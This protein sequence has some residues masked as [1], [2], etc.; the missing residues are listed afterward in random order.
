MKIGPQSAGANPGPVCYNI[1]GRTAT[2]TDANVVLGYLN[3]EGL[4]GGTRPIY[5]ELAMQVIK[6]Q[7]ADPLAISTEDAAYGA[8]R[9]AASNMIR[10][11]K[12]VSSERGRDPREFALVAFGGNGPLFAAGMAEALGITTII[13]PPYPG[14]FSAFGLLYSDI[15]KHHTKAFRFATHAVR[16]SDL[17]NELAKLGVAASQEFI[18]SG[19]S[20]DRISVDRFAKLQ[21]VG[22]AHGQ[23]VP[24]PAGEVDQ[25]TLDNMV[26]MFAQ[27]HDRT[28][29]HRA[30]AGEL[31]EF[32]SLAIIAR[33]KPDASWNPDEL[34]LLDNDTRKLTSRHAYF[35]P[36]YGWQEAR[37]IRR[38]D[39]HNGLDGPCIVEEY[40]GTTLVP[41]GAKAQLD[42][43]RNIVVTLNAERIVSVTSPQMSVAEV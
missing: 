23:Y 40:D 8:H 21:Y 27:E 43:H 33:M 30:P 14:V 20:T 4:A 28:Y 7:I 17:N 42:N 38:A 37:V 34:R 3:P 2:V 10:A 39:I 36:K 16:L 32:I 6:T 26:E 19:V 12:A 24:F 29:G 1:G 15:E 31:V 9:I 25:V 18:R 35:G 41:P 22:Q 13:V 5:P 11:I